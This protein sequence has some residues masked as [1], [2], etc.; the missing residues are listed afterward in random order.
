[1]SLF[2][3]QSGSCSFVA[4]PSLPQDPYRNGVR[5]FATGNATRATTVGPY[6]VGVSGL[7]FDAEGKVLVVDSTAGLP[8]GT[9]YN[10]GLPIS[11]A[12]ELCVADD[13]TVSYNHGMPYTANGSIRGTIL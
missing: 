1:M 11:P 9:A 8:P 13:A 7:L 12:G 10:N 5:L 3:V 6:T 4:L 2:P